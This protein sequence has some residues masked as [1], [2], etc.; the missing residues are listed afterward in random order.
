MILLRKLSGLGY[1]EISIACRISVGSVNNFSLNCISAILKYANGVLVWPDESQ[2]ATISR[3]I[4]DISGIPNC[5]GLIDGTLY[6]LKNKPIEVGANYWTRKCCYAINAQIVCTHDRKI[7]YLYTGWS[8]AVH[9]QRA[10]SNS[11][12]VLSAR[13]YFNDSQH[14]LG[15]S[16]YTPSIYIIPCFKKGPNTELSRKCKQFN[17]RIAKVRIVAEHVIG[18]QKARFP[19]LKAIG[20]VVD[21]SPESLQKCVDIITVCSILH[22]WLVTDELKQTWIEEAKDYE[23]QLGRYFAAQS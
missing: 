23:Q 17:Y 19:Y 14:L 9:D 13:K 2:R 20:Y 6:P 21:N 16:A 7:T 15:D 22:N 10:I 8:G 1:D 18:M 3:Q 4:E 12:L 11:D 5:V